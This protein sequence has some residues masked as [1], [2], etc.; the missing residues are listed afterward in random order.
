MSEGWATD[1]KQI[2]EHFIEEFKKFFGSSSSQLPKNLNDYAVPCILE[3]KNRELMALPLEDEIKRYIWEMHPL[4][5]LGPDGFL[6]GFF[7]MYWLI[8]KKQII[9]FV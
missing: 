2:G 1:R 4:K 7:R 5:S 8:I 9:K 6:G 3:L